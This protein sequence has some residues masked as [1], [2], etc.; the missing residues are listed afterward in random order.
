MFEI[1]FGILDQYWENIPA[2]SKQQNA[3]ILN[4]L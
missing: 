3:Q 2:S 1:S 4:G